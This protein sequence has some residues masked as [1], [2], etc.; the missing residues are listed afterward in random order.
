[1]A[2]KNQYSTNLNLTSIPEFEQKKYPEIWADSL[3][4]RNAIRGLQGALDL[5]TGALSE[6][7]QYWSTT[8]AGSSTRV[9][10]ITRIYA[11]ALEDITLGQT[12]HLTDSA[13]SLAARKA[14]A[15]DSTKPARA[16][17]SKIDGVLTGQWGEFFMLG[18]A[19]YFTGLTPGTPFYLS[20]TTSGVITNV[21]PTGAGNII[22]PVGFALDAGSV[23]FNPSLNWT[24][25]P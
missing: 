18:V 16:I 6:D 5:Y 9:Q 21:A 11:I 8:S 17:C 4:I 10:S 24:V 14:N 15:T 20:A 23:W 7:D 2:E 22:Q 12:V 25:H 19:N 1:M 3:R 13:G